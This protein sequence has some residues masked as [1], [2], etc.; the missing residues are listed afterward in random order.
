MTYDIYLIINKINSKKYIGLTKKDCWVRF[1][2]H[3]KEARSDSQR[4]IC[5]AIRKY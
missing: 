5:R 3:I 2:E 1:Y 4:A